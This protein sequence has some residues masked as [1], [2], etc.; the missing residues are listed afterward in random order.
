MLITDVCMLENLTILEE[1]KSKGT[2]KV[3]GVFQRANEANN[4][5]R[6]YPLPVLESQLKKVMPLVTER[7]LCGELDHPSTDTVSLSNVSHLITGLEVK[8]N[9]II[10]EA[11][12]LNTPA[13]MTA[14]ALVRDGVRVGISS[15]GMG[16]LSESD[17]GNK[18]VNEDYN[19]ITFDL[20]ADPSTRG[21]FPSLS[22]SVQQEICE[23]V[24]CVRESLKKKK[25]EKVFT[26]MLKNKLQEQYVPDPTQPE[27]IQE[28]SSSLA[29]DLKSSLETVNSLKEQIKE[30][31]S[32]IA[33]TKMIKHMEKPG[34][35]VRVHKSETVHTQ[36]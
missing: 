21:A 26:T 4:N 16:T 8:G 23:G 36:G 6:I 1:S 24:K 25:Q 13:G 12:L 34:I 31:R 33:Q 17:N 30:A 3:R 27:V 18:T 29:E 22:E 2:M 35:P 15:R 19:L 14:Q 20:V 5:K 11:E 9:D 28:E 10:G 7:R 32:K